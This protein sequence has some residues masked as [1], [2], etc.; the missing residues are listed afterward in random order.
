MTRTRTS[1]V[2]MTRTKQSK[3]KAGSSRAHPTVA[4]RSRLLTKRHPP[5]SKRRTQVENGVTAVIELSSDD[6]YTPPDVVAQ[7]TRP[8][9]Y[10]DDLQITAEGK[11]DSLQLSDVLPLLHSS[12][13]VR[14]EKRKPL[15][16]AVSHSNM[17]LQIF[18]M[19][20]G[21]NCCQNQG[22]HGPRVHPFRIHAKRAH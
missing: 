11:K 7:P 10:G 14:Y 19:A 5:F 12:V 8:I 22:I 17:L 3:R 20:L 9:W 2:L 15:K 18:L 6:E 4:Q 13:G 1:L 16:T 21:N